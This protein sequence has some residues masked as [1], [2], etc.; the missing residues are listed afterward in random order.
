MSE[1]VEG[2][3]RGMHVLALVAKVCVVR[4]VRL[5]AE[6]WHCQQSACSR[7]RQLVTADS[8]GWKCY[9]TLKQMDGGVLCAQGCQHGRR[10][11]QQHLRA[12]G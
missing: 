9:C 2:E 5:G 1:R 3:S 12:A 8:K 10:Q 4:F 7:P 6:H 11:P